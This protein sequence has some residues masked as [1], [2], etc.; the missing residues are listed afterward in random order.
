MEEGMNKMDLF[1]IAAFVSYKKLKSNILVNFMDISIKMNYN[2][3][4]DT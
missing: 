2:P 3:I 4:F 1:E